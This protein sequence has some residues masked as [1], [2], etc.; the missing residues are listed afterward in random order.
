MVSHLFLRCP[1]MFCQ[2]W[3]L[4]CGYNPGIEETSKCV[5]LGVD[6]LS[7]NPIM[8]ESGLIEINDLSTAGS[9]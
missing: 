2:V 8:S 6:S 1:R 4:A 5:R 9:S 7:P 3:I